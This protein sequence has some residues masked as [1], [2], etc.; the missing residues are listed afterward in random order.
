MVLPLL[1]SGMRVTV[2]SALVLTAALA[3]GC[4]E[5]TAP[6]PWKSVALDFCEGPVPTW[7]AVQN[8]GDR[9]RELTADASGTFAFEATPRVSVA[10]VFASSGYATTIYN[11]TRDELEMFAP[12]LCRQPSGTRSLS[13]SVAGVTGG[14]W[15]SLSIGGSGFVRGSDVT[16]FSF[17]R[18]AD[19]PLD[20]VATRGN[21]AGTFDRVIVRS[22]VNQPSGATL[23]T[24][25]F[26][27]AE[28][29][30]LTAHTVTIANRGSDDFYMTSA[31]VSANGTYHSLGLANVVTGSSMAATVAV[32]GT[33]SAAGDFHHLFASATNHATGGGRYMTVYT[34]NP[35][36][37]TLTLGPELST[38]SI[39]IATIPYLRPRVAIPSQREYPS[40]MEAYFSQQVGCAMRVHAIHTSAGFVGRRPATW[41]LE[42]PDMTEAGYQSVWAPQGVSVAWQTRGVDGDMRL[43]LQGA[44]RDGDV[45]RA[46]SRQ[47]GALLP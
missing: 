38:P 30:P 27:S 10:Y 6:E 45:L 1:G 9:W 33:L 7:L 29:L 37:K 47:G 14:E 40:A 15:V 44:P 26:S 22:S 23:P 46:A 28:A 18:L 3:A 19:A 35:V 8:D 36:G 39:S 5:T 43:V 41:Q 16:T 42:L 13:G 34:A 31:F 20:L 32:P 17:N 11:L 24:L 2:L 4:S 12:A 25:D 21:P